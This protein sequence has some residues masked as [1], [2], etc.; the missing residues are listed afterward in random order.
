MYNEIGNKLKL[1]R[2]KNN[3]KQSDLAKIL[4]VSRVQI[5]NIE[6][7]RRGLNLEQLNMLCKRFKIDISY[8][9]NE[10]ITFEGELLLSKAKA[11]FNSN[12]LTSLAKEDLFE[13]LLNI[14]MESK[15]E[16]KNE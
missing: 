13:E 14:Y 4:N 11:L 2:V 16:Q 9:F 6:N 12:S 8:F 7:G 1:L 10:D 5:C 3:L 15:E